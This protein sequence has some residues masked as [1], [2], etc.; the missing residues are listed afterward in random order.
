VSPGELAGDGD[1]LGGGRLA[2]RFTVDDLVA[3]DGPRVRLSDVGGEVLE[4]DRLA[5]SPRTVEGSL[6]DLAGVE[7]A[8]EPVAAGEHLRWSC[9][10]P[11]E[12][13][14]VDIFRKLSADGGGRE[15]KGWSAA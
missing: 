15:G 9:P 6:D 7:A 3:Q 13:A 4:Q 11:G 5:H 8:A 12:N 14:A 2:Q 1:E 10:N